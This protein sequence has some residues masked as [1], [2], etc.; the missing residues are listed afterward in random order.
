[1]YDVVFHT[2]SLQIL[3]NSVNIQLFNSHT[4]EMLNKSILSSDPHQ[5]TMLH[6]IKLDP[7]VQCNMV[8]PYTG[9]DDVTFVVGYLT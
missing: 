6:S 4:L 8:H 3:L 7:T 5:S 2:K 1:M 9:Q